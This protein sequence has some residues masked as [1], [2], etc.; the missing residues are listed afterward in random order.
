MS[1]GVYLGDSDALVARSK[2]MYIGDKDGIARSVLKAYIGD[3]DGIARLC[4]GHG[5]VTWKK[6]DAVVHKIYT[7]TTGELLPVSSTFTLQ[8]NTGFSY[9]RD[10]Q[11]SE[12]QG[13]YATQNESMYLRDVSAEAVER[14]I[15]AYLVSSRG[16][17]GVLILDASI[18][19][20]TED[21]AI[22]RVEGF[23]NYTADYEIT[24]FEKGTISVFP[25]QVTVDEGQ[26]PE[27][28]VVMEGSVNGDY[29]V[30]RQGQHGVNDRYYYYTRM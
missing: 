29:C 25:H 24:G 4:Y 15:G 10:I 7:E 11:F 28:G 5:V 27:A 19:S 26:I 2:V 3:K 22:V 9:S 17:Y 21:E 18:I 16:V 14:L 6:N 30:V 23:R 13:W 12:T 20:L 1:K 8:K